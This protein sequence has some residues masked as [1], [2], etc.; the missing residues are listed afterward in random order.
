MERL[1]QLFRDFADGKTRTKGAL[2]YRDEWLEE[3]GNVLR[4]REEAGKRTVP[5]PPAITLL[6]RFVMPGRGREGGRKS[7]VR[8]R[9]AQG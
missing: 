7:A 5:N 6:V 3:W 4:M 8:H 1:R 9:P 2:C